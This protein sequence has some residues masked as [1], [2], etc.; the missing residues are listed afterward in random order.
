MRTFDLA[1]TTYAG[2]CPPGVR[3]APW[4]VAIDA[5]CIAVVG[6]AVL[7][8][9]T[10]GRGRAPARQIMPGMQ[11]SPVASGRPAARP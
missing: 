5:A 7:V 3:S 10:A 11:R 6:G 2:S 9:V 8:R 4:M 1:P